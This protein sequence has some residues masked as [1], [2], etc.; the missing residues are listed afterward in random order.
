MNRHF[1][2]SVLCLLAWAPEAVAQGTV[3]S[4]NLLAFDGLSTLRVLLPE[5]NH[6][7]GH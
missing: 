7:A 5:W 6:L 2:A 4:G 1:V 3:E